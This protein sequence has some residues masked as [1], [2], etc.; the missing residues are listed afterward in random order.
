MSDKSE[1]VELAVEGNPPSVI[2][3]ILGKSINTVN[4]EIAR[5]RRQGFAIPRFQTGRRPHCAQNGFLARYREAAAIR[6]IT[7][8]ELIH[9]ILDVIFKDDLIN[10]IL[11]DAVQKSPSIP[12][13]QGGQK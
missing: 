6:G 5:G 11:D 2:A 13:D 10:A 3:A 8:S 4:I 12:D 7:V 9:Q 1:I